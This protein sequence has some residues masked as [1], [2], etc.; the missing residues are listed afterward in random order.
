ML[1][2]YLI[3]A[4]IICILH[5]FTSLRVLVILTAIGWLAQGFGDFL[6]GSHRQ[7]SARLAHWVLGLITIGGAIVL[8]FWPGLSLAVLVWLAG[9]FLV[10]FG[11]LQ[12]VRVLSARIA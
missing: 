6:S 12:L 1:G 4:G 7:G 2:L 5:P 10:A 9:W 8:L 11:V 3:V